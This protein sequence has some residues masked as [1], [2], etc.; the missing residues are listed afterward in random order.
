LANVLYLLFMSAAYAMSSGLLL[1]AA[2]QASLKF[3]AASQDLGI[4]GACSP[5]GYAGTCLLFGWIFEKYAGKWI[6][7]SGIVLGVVAAAQLFLATSVA[8]VGLWMFIFG[9]SSGAFWPFTSAWMFDF[10]APDLSKTKILRLYNVGWSSGTAIGVFAGGYITRAYSP[11][12]TFEVGAFVLVAAFILSLIPPATRNSLAPSSASA[13]GAGSGTVRRVGVA[14]LLAAVIAN[15]SAL[16]IRSTVVVNY[17]EL[18]SFSGYQADRMG[19]FV[20]CSMAGQMIAFIFGSLYEPILGLR[21]VY[22]A[23]AFSI[24]LVCLVFAFSDNLFVLIAAS[25]LIGLLSAVAFQCNIIAATECFSTPRM[26]TTF[27]EAT[28]G[29]GGLAPIPAGFLTDALKGRASEHTALQSPFFAIAAIVLLGLLLQLWLVS[30]SASRRVLLPAQ[31]V[32][33]H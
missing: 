18:N 17:A 8:G 13:V 30:T 29:L 27:H 14:L 10:V 31:P 33:Q 5:I 15:L 4:M 1:V 6:V 25:L 19:I 32:P 20:A 26:G 16:G 22:A 3:G 12:L 28:V 24:V 9:I 2:P 7:A 21:R 23:I 11:Q